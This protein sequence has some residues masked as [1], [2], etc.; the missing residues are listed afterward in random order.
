MEKK[1]LRI[2][3]I[4]LKKNK[5]GGLKLLDFK[6]YYKATVI[7]TECYW[8]KN[9]QM[10]QWNRIASPEIYPHNQ[11]QL[12]FDKGAKTRQWRKDNLFNK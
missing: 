5:I 12:T 9:R 6:I 11:N 10:N 4:L 1:R 8:Q 2:A 3:N 7:K